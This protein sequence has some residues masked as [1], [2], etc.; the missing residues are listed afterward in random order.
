M[1]I[2]IIAIFVGTQ[3]CWFWCHLLLVSCEIYSNW[4]QRRGIVWWGLLRDAH[5]DSGERSSNS[6]SSGLKF[7]IQWGNLCASHGRIIM[8]KHSALLIAGTMQNN[9][10]DVFL[11]FSLL[12]TFAKLRNRYFYVACCKISKMQVFM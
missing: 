4:L 12:D 2:I 7:V 3:G 9:T 1:V 8:S 6:K 10:P 5:F 11:L